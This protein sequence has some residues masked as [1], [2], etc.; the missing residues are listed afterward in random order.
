MT[1]GKSTAALL[2]EIALD[3]FDFGRVKSGYHRPGD[4]EPIVHVF[5]RPK[6]NPKQVRRL[7]DI[8]PDIAAVFEAQYGK[9]P[10]ARALGDAMTV[11]EGKARQAGPAEDGGELA[12][13][14]GRTGPKATQLV[15][16]ARECYRSGVTANGDVFGVPSAGPNI[17]RPLRGGRRSLRAELAARFYRQ[18][19]TTPSAQALADALAVLQGE[20]QG[21]EPV[22]TAL[23]AGQDPA[24]GDLVLDLGREEGQV[25]VI[26]PDGW[27]V[28]TSS[29]VMFWR[30][31]ATLPLPVPS[32]GG[33]L[34]ALRGL[35]NLPA[36]D[37]P[38]AVAWAV[39]ALFPA[40]PHPVLLLRGEHGT[41]KSWTARMLTSLADPSASQLRTAPRNVEDWCVG[42]AASW[43]A[44]LDNTSSLAPWLQD[45]LCRA[46]TGDGLL[47]RALHTDS[48][49]SVLAFRRVIA[50][51]AIDPGPLSG[52]LADRALVM[53]PQRITDASRVPEAD[54]AAA[55]R[56][57]HPGVLGALLD[58]AAA[59]L[60]V[61]PSVRRSGLPRMA[62]FARVTL[63]VDKVMGT[64]GF[65][66]FCEQAE[67][68]SEHVADSDPVIIAI[69]EHITAPWQGSAA[70]CLAMLTPARPPQGWPGTPQA[71]GARLSRAAPV[72][73]SLGWSVDSDRTARQRVW[74]IAPPER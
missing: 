69:R 38:L 6:N 25:V 44:C 8:R 54:L 41:A 50:L 35:L 37:W 60:A 11:L 64:D 62:D 51:T 73:R 3:L 66:R 47:R 56:E 55:W 39:A 34:D 61:L 4:P 49:V 42:L 27:R 26:G 19:G 43:I 33:S 30:T 31:A 28:T 21:T 72:L 68:V 67:R 14:L 70:E 29:P 2:V 52:D 18:T 74:C 71:L 40:M 23:R 59:V 48:D 9:P 13:Q 10:S 17:A 1:G 22:E 63:A 36:G 20:A 46:V 16:M 15:T 24:T 53:E 65:G 7:E 12:A 5:A 57:V 58:V 45:A 32:R